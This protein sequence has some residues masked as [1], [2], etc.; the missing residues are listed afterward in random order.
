MQLLDEVAALDGLAD[1]ALHR[2]QAVVDGFAGKQ[3]LLD[4][5]AQHPL[6]HGGAGLIQHPKQRA[7]LFAA[8]QRL[9][10]FEV[11]AGHGRKAHVL[12]LAVAE[13]RLQPL[14]ALDLGGVEVFQQCGH[15]KADEPLLPDGRFLR[16]IA[17]ELI[18]QRESHEAGR[19]F[20]LFHH[21]DRAGQALFDIGRHFTAVQHPRV[22]QQLAGAVAA[23][24]RNDSGCD[25]ALLELGDMGCA[26]GDIRKADARRIPLDK[27][28]GD[29]VVAV[30]L[31]HAVFNDRAGRDDT[32]NVPLD[33][34]LC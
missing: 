14:H 32:D 23:E 13:H 27:D 28:A 33:E 12:G 17:A 29:V 11:G 10:E 4:P 3:G 2:V 6:A 19:I 24:L 5:A 18:F 30:I 31:Q 34:A 1:Q 26:G 8:A 22:H 25:L 21:L 20:F 15:G 16:P 9:G 7:P